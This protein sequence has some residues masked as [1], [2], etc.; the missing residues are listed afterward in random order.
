MKATERFDIIVIG[1]GPAGSVSAH[2]CAT[3]GR[4]VLMLDKATFP[5][6]KVCGC[7]LS[8]VG[9]EALRDCGL[10]ERVRAC[11]SVV[12]ERFKLHVRGRQMQVDVPPGLAISRAALDQALIEAAVSQGVRFE[13]GV[14]AVVE[15][16]DEATQTREVRWHDADGCERRAAAA[17]V[18]LAGGLGAIRALRQQEIHW[19]E[20][21]RSR[22]GCSTLVAN[23][24][25]LE[26][27]SIDMMT[28]RGGYVGLSRLEDGQVDIAAAMDPSFVQR[29]GGVGEAVA[30]IMAQAGVSVPQGIREARWRGTPRLTAGPNRVSLA[31]LLLVGD[32]SGYV[33]PFTGEGMTWAILGGAALAP[34]ASDTTLSPA[35]IAQQW[36]R[37]HRR[38]L[39]SRQRKCR[40]ITTLLRSERLTALAVSL[41]NTSRHAR[42]T[43]IAATHRPAVLTAPASQR[44]PS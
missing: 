2:Q 18:V 28:S 36:Q 29:S 7:C 26:Q 43:V 3:R 17:T 11:S 6:H 4:S 38:L 12:L 21:Q 15:P 42:R 44:T 16:F 35:Q 13:Q 41:L 31:G 1:A 37:Q 30:L 20:H 8:H 40:A 33:E 32:A 5:R 14:T 23:V 25:G 34:I 22:I 19:H 39:A 9:L 10:E 27:G 24:P